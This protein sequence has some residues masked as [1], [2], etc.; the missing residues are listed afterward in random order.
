MAQDRC[1]RYIAVPERPAPAPSRCSACA[2]SGPLSRECSACSP[3]I[4]RCSHVGAGLK[5]QRAPPLCACAA[6]AWNVFRMHANAAPFT[7]KFKGPPRPVTQELRARPFRVT[8]GLAWASAAAPM[9]PPGS[10]DSCLD[11]WY[12]KTHVFSPLYTRPTHR[13]RYTYIHEHRRRA[14]IVY[15]YVRLLIHIAASDA[16][17]SRTLKRFHGAMHSL[18]TADVHSTSSCCQVAAWVLGFQ[19]WQAGCRRHSHPAPS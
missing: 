6:T 13:T 7:F 11:A 5:P 10:T 3:C 1:S 4:H 8:R 2:P 14:L 12:V 9:S 16:N 17:D 18:L 15:I 19:R